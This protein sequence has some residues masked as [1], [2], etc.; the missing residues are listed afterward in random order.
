MSAAGE[1]RN[2][3]TSGSMRER[4]SAGRQNAFSPAAAAAGIHASEINMKSLEEIER[5]IGRS[6]GTA[7]Y[8]TVNTDPLYLSRGIREAYLDGDSD[9]QEVINAVGRFQKGDFGTAEQ[10]GKREEAGHE[11][12]RY[13]GSVL[14]DSGHD[15]CIWV[16]RDGDSLIAYFKCER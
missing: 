7:Y 6:R 2:L 3:R 9:I 11:Y 12:G 4:R 8:N 15:A 13:E 16:H 14:S 1:V 10:A 5:K